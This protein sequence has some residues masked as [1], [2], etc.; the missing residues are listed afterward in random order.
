MRGARGVLASFIVVVTAAVVT[1]LPALAQAGPSATDGTIWQTGTQPV[2]SL[3]AARQTP[4]VQPSPQSQPAGNQTPQATAPTSSSPS[5]GVAFANG[6]LYSGVTLGTFYDDNVFATNT[7]RMHDWAFFAR[8]EVSWLQQGQN[9]TYTADGYIEGLDYSRFSSEDQ[10]NGSVGAGFTIMPDKDSQIIG[11]ARYIH[12][13][14]DR[15]ASETVIT[16]PGG[17]STLLTT[18]FEH[19]VAYDEG[20]ESVALNKR[21]GN[22]WSSLGLAGL[23]INYQNPSIG[24]TS[25]LAGSSVNLNYGDGAITAINGRIGYVVMPLTSVFGEA[26]VNARD[27]G[28]NYFDSTGYRL[29]GGMLFEQGP[30]ARLKGEIWGGYMAQQYNGITLQQVSSWTYGIG[31]N[32]VVADN[33]TAVIEGRREA[34]EAALGLAILPD[35]SLGASTATCMTIGGAVCVS[36]IESEIG[37]RLDYHIQPKV[38]V[39]AGVTYLEDDYQG[40][41][42]FGRVDRTVSPLV[43]VKYLMTPTITLGFDYRNVGFSSTGGSATAPATSVSALP[44]NRNI[45]MLSMNARW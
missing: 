40:P 15:G 16:L 8:P 22:W 30:G 33:V 29:V 27:W 23:E 24:G 17:E 5:P 35:G 9:Y 28:V 2:P 1:A 38:V 18:L 21:Y 20:V 14:L 36:T 31:L 45:Y 19:P 4:N 34:K 11:S 37:G 44:Y 13:H 42:A 26:A 10:I 6:T 43:S 7:N 3:Y 32:A 41:L 39:G 25:P 12:A